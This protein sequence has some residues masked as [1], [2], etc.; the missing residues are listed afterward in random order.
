MKRSPTKT[1]STEPELKARKRTPYPFVIDALE[2]L[3]PWTRSMFGCTAIYV[4]EKIVL[5]LREKPTS[6]IDNG[7]WLATTCDH[8]ESL[9]R[10]FPNMRSIAVLGKDVT[11]W[12][13]LPADAPDFEESAVRACEL[14]AQRDHRIG[15]VPVSKQRK[16]P[17]RAKSR[18]RI[19]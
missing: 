15:K 16:R 5:C 8:H 6:L 1:H 12:Q 9:R 10:D 4:G 3:S 17:S 13:L 18:T 14:I 2:P 11:G 7:V 19:K